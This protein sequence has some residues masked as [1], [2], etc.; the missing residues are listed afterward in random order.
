MQEK[1]K[2]NFEFLKE[3]KFPEF[4]GNNESDIISQMMF[5]VLLNE[6]Q[7]FSYFKN[8][9]ESSLKGNDEQFKQ[10]VRELYT[11]SILDF[12]N[13]NPHYIDILKENEE[14]YKE[15]AKFFDFFGIDY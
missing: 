7:S 9:I 15:I 10:E 8:Y 11:N 1:E 3:L 4:D 14:K 6:G 5:A 13:R 2:K 12:L